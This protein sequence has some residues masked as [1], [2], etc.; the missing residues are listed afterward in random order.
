MPQNIFFPRTRDLLVSQKTTKRHFF[1]PLIPFP[2]YFLQLQQWWQLYSFAVLD[3]ASIVI[4][5]VKQRLLRNRP[6]S[7]PRD[8]SRLLAQRITKD[9]HSCKPAS[10]VSHDEKQQAETLSV[11]NFSGIYIYLFVCGP[12]SR[13]CVLSPNSIVC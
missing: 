8:L 10:L 5:S 12:G 13:N 9:I 3:S 6:G 4:H 1:P 11:P 7:D 2:L